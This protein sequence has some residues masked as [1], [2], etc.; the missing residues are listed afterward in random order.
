MG[1][2]SR[3]FLV[4][5]LL[6]FSV[7]NSPA[8]ASPGGRSPTTCDGTWQVVP[9]PHVGRS[10]YLEDVS[11]D[12]ATDAWA[13][14][15]WSGA[16]GYDRTLVEHWDGLTWTVV[17][18]PSPGPLYSLLTD[19]VALSPTDVWAVGI[20]AGVNTTH[21][22]VEHWDGTLWSVVPSVDVGNGENDL[23]GVTAFGTDDVWAVGQQFS[24]QGSL[25]IE[26]WDGASWTRTPASYRPNSSGAFLGVAGAASN[27]VWAVGNS[28]TI[29]GGPTRTLAEHWDGTAWT[30][31][32]TVNPR[33]R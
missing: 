2:P 27:D 17:S 7:A 24:T 23:F 19:V 6:S 22:L 15:G 30:I 28:T 32:P 12:S 11:A 25:L 18:S 20:Q 1:I 9:S 33:K 29:G 8:H 4:L 26:H 13:V 10:S 5:L 21:T 31:V 16:I 3:A 14:G